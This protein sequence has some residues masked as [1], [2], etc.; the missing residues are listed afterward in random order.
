MNNGA[1]HDP[2]ECIHIPQYNKIFHFKNEKLK[3]IIFDFILIFISTNI[4][5][6]IQEKEKRLTIR[7]FKEKHRKRK[8]RNK[9]KKKSGIEYKK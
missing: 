4:N 8:N 6:N 2:F 9:I 7:I 5:P 1:T 3:K